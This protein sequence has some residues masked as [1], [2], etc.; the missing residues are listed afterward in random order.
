[1]PLFKVCIIVCSFPTFA[2]EGEGMGK[3]SLFARLETENKTYEVKNLLENG[4]EIELS[5]LEVLKENEHF[6]G[7]LIVPYDYYNEIIVEDLKLQCKEEREGRYFCEFKS[8]SPEQQK[9]LNFIMNCFNKKIIIH[10]P[11][12]SMNYA[13]SKAVNSALGKLAEKERGSLKALIG[14]LA[15]L[16][17]ILIFIFSTR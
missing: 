4:L 9:L 10:A 17:G 1:L 8:L 6:S 16:A 7:K 11:Q 2:V 5:P 15:L 13:E 3:V 12:N 14:F